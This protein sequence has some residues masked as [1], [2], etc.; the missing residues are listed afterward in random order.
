MILG[1]AMLFVYSMQ[2]RRI[3][4]HKKKMHVYCCNGVFFHLIGCLAGYP[5]NFTVMELCTRV[6]DSEIVEVTPYPG[7]GQ[8]QQFCAVKGN[9]FW[10][11]IFTLLK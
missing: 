8:V 2:T 11:L 3:S 6:S 7:E 5:S 1:M 10:R 4:S 9:H